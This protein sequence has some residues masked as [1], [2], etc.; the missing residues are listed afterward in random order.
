MKNRICKL[1]SFVLCLTLLLGL[2][3]PARAALT[4]DGK[5]TLTFWLHGFDMI[6]ED[7]EDTVDGQIDML[8]DDDSFDD[9]PD[10]TIYIDLELHALIIRCGDQYRTYIIDNEWLSN[11]FASC[12]CDVV[13]D[14]GLMDEGVRVFMSFNEESSGYL[15]E[16]MVRTFVETVDA[17]D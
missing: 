13:L 16:E 2:C 10:G 7:F 4:K 9:F 3:L 1:V 12:V 5:D 8:R 6:F 11:F 17:Q 15:T 14:E